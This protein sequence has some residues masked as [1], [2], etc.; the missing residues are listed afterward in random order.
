[1][2]DMNE[3]CARSASLWL[4]TRCGS[5]ASSEP[6]NKS[7]SRREIRV[8]LRDDMQICRRSSFLALKMVPVTPILRRIRNS[9]PSTAEAVAPRINLFTDSRDDMYPSKAGECSLA[10]KVYLR[11]RVARGRSSMALNESSSR[12]TRGETFQRLGNVCVGGCA[13]CGGYSVNPVHQW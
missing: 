7:V 6:V 9:G 8:P 2:G 12:S 3:V 4:A 13:A 5:C 1:M 10:T 11:R